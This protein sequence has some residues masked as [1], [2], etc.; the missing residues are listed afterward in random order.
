MGFFYSS[1]AIGDS[2]PAIGKMGN[3]VKKFLVR[4]PRPLSGWSF[5]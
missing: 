5:T 2:Y 3:F 4:W 1:I